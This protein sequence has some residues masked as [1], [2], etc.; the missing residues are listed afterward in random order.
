LFTRN[1][2]PDRAEKCDGLIL[3]TLEAGPSCA[4]SFLSRLSYL[5]LTSYAIKTF[6]IVLLHVYKPS[7]SV[8][9]QRYEQESFTCSSLSSLVRLLIPQGSSRTLQ[10]SPCPSYRN[11]TVGAGGPLQR[12]N[13]VDLSRFGSRTRFELVM[14]RV[15]LGRVGSQSGQENL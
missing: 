2:I 3:V 12:S 15:G 5:C 7:R 8:G 14:C 9:T 11:Q 13:Q 10:F 1:T 6:L 4:S